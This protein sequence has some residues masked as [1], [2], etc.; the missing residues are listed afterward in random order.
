MLGFEEVFMIKQMKDQGMYINFGVY[1]KYFTP[2]ETLIGCHERAFQYFDGIP[3]TIL[4]DSMRT[5]VKNPS[6]SGNEKWNDKFFQ[7]SKHSSFVP[8]RCR[9]YT[10]R[11]KGKVENGVK[12]VRRNFWPRIFQFT[13]LADLNKRAFKWVEEVANKRVHG[14]TKEVPDERSKLEN[15]KPITG[16]NFQLGYVEERKVSIDC[17]VTFQSNRYSVP[18]QYVKKH[19]KV[20]DPKNGMIEIFSMDGQRIALHEKLKE[21]NKVRYKKEHFQEIEQRNLK[22]GAHQAPNLIPDTIPEV[23]ERPLSAYEDVMN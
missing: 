2:S 19:V 11:T 9:P 21:K 1:T 3:E 22:K 8:N 13:S 12:Y 14:T 23:Q 15:L 5:V 18:A 16:V 7:F 6:G 17:F 20:K 4:Y 10:L